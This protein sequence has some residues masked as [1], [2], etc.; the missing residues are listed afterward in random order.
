[1]LPSELPFLAKSNC[2]KFDICNADVA[3]ASATRVIQTESQGASQHL[4]S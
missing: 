2:Q 3:T 4:S 1:M